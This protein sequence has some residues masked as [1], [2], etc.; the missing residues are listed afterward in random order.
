MR[1]LVREFVPR[2]QIITTEEDTDQT[3]MSPDS[4]I[5]FESDSTITNITYD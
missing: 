1:M 3:L 4:Y 5:E 2:I